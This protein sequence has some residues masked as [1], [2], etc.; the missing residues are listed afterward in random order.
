M[1]SI[2]NMAINMFQLAGQMN[3]GVDVPK[4]IRPLSVFALGERLIFLINE[5]FTALHI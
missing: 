3:F 4:E 5:K 1:Y 2:V